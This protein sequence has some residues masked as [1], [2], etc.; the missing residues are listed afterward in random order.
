V[1]PTETFDSIWDALEPSPAAATNMRL[2]SDLLIAVQQ[3]VASWGVT[4]VAAARRLGISQPRLSDLL[5]GRISKFSLDGLV[6]LA[7]RAGLVVRVD[8]A[9]AAA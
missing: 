4:Q 7:T 6:E 9:R 1:T 3:A 8:I 5:K 2:R